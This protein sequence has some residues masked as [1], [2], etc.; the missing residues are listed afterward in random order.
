MLGVSVQA[1][2]RCFARDR[3]LRAGVPHSGRG[4]GAGEVCGVVRVNIE[5]SADVLC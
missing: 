4:E 2:L 5:D 1:G 3:S